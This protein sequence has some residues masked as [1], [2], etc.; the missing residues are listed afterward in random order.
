MTKK[1]EAVSATQ[2]GATFVRSEAA[3][4]AQADAIRAC[5]PKAL[6]A[7]GLDDAIK[8]TK[9]A[10]AKAIL[11]F[12]EDAETSAA[13]KAQAFDML[14][15]PKEGDPKLRSRRKSDKSQLAL[16]NNIRRTLIKL[17]KIKPAETK[18]LTPKQKLQ[19]DIL[20]LFEAK[21]SKMTVAELK[22]EQA[23]LEGEASH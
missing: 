6:P 18:P 16:F 21:L 13:E 3:A 15:V 7:G 4:A 2:N 8:T 23:K 9:A 11:A 20:A 19:A 5:A 17:Y 1:V 22:A 14:D 12:A 10:V